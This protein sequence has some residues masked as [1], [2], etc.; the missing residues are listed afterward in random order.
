MIKR[1]LIKRVA[2]IFIFYFLLVFAWG[3]DVSHVNFSIKTYKGYIDNDYSITLQLTIRK[4][5]DIPLKYFHKVYG[6]YFYNMY[7]LP[8][9]FIGVA[10]KDSVNFKVYNNKESE[11]F[12][13][14]F[15][16]DSITGNWIKNGKSSPF[17]LVPIIDYKQKDIICQLPISFSGSSCPRI[18]SQNEYRFFIA[19]TDDKI[20]INMGNS[21]QLKIFDV[22]SLTFEKTIDI[23]CFVN[24]IYAWREGVIIVSLTDI[25]Y[26]NLEKGTVIWKEKIPLIWYY[27]TYLKG[28]KIY[29]Y[30]ISNKQEKELICFD[31]VS[32]CFNIP[33]KGSKLILTDN[34]FAYLYENGKQLKHISISGDKEDV[35]GHKNPMIHNVNSIN[36][37][38][39]WSKYENWITVANNNMDILWKFKT[40]GD[41]FADILQNRYLLLYGRNT[42]LYDLKSHK[43]LWVIEQPL[44]SNYVID[45]NNLYF[46]SN[47]VATAIDLS[48]G[49][50]LWFFEVKGG[51][52][53][54]EACNMIFFINS[55]TLKPSSMIT[56]IRKIE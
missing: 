24:K 13:G 54:F 20:I 30:N 16:N 17:Y 39:F 3:Q 6:S 45:G 36:A 26:I 33:S 48:T 56:G 15:A 37:F 31:L 12:I 55:W 46:I 29:F 47:E 1:N 23:E 14:K 42:K 53:V 32:K 28:G 34:N 50:I 8:I 4:E 38:Y 2:I 25:Y 11:E 22:Q 5:E 9:E 18:D 19:N 35:Y 21:K 44:T 10:I 43:L 27:D 49:S 7:K 51:R 41:Y 40:S 52:E